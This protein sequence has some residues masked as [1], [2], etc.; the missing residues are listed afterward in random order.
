MPC[1]QVQVLMTID[2]EEITFQTSNVIA[3]KTEAPPQ[4]SGIGLYNVRKRLELLYAGRHQLLIA[5]EDSR[6]V[7][8]LSI[9]LNSQK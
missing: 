6:F 9:Q 7:V 2:E 5:E 8:T 1:N 4:E 3:P